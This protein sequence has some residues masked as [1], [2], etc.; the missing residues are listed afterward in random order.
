MEASL[1]ILDHAIKILRLLVTSLR[2]RSGRLFQ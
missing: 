1:Q 2:D